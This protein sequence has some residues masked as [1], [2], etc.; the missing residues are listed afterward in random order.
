MVE[1]PRKIESVADLR[2]LERWGRSQERKPDGR[3]RAKRQATGLGI[4]PA[5]AVAPRPRSG[6]VYSQAELA[7][8]C[9]C[10]ISTV[11]D[12][13]ARGVKAGH[14]MVKLETV[15]VPRGGVTPGALAEFLTRV[16]G[17][18]FSAGEAVGREETQKTQ[19]GTG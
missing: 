15:R 5:V 11:R 19:K 4:R 14:G 3:K 13:V 16:N 9:E 2:Q 6:L 18:R 10:K 12:W 1:K 8:I 7:E 17:V